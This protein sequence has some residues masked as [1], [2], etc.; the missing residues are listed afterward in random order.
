MELENFQAVLKPKYDGT[1][2]LA[3][4]FPPESLDFFILLSSLAGILGSLSQANYAAA[5]T[6]Q[7]MFANAQASRGVNKTVSIDLPL[8]QGTH[9]MSDERTAWLARQGGE[10]APIETV[11]S[12][13]DYAMSGRAAK[14]GC[15]QIVHGV[16]PHYLQERPLNRVPPLLRNVAASGHVTGQ[17]AEKGTERS[18]EDSIAQ[19]STVEAVTEVI[20]EAVRDKMSSLTTMDASEISLDTPVTNLGLDSLIAIEIKNWVTNTLQAPVRVG[21]IMDCSSLRALATL[22]AE[23]S[24]LIRA[25]TEPRVNGK[26]NGEPKATSAEDSQKQATQNSSSSNG[27]EV[28]LPKQP[29]PSLEATMEVFLESVANLGTQ[30]EL[31]RT[32]AAIN[33]FLGS[34]GLG[35]RLQQRLEKLANDPKVDNWL[36]D[37][38]GKGLW[39]KARDNKPRLN[40]FFGSHRLTRHPHSQAERAALISLA[41]YRYKLSLDEETVE[42]DYLNDQP[43]CMESVHWLFNTNRTPVEGC[44]RVDAWPGNEY[45]IAMRR[46]HVYKVPLRDEDGN[47]ILHNSLKSIF[48]LILEQA[49]KEANITS[50][51]TTGNRDTWAKVSMAPGISIQADSPLPPVEPAAINNLPTN[52]TGRFATKS[53]RPAGK[54]QSL[55]PP[56]RS[57]SLPSVW[58][59]ERL[60]L[61]VSGRPT[62]CSTTIPTAGSTR[63]S[64]SSYA[65]TGRPQPCTSTHELTA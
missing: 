52:M 41:A 16:S 19:A 37:I 51:L 15:N 47:I 54:M 11:L 23:R 38:Y 27:K 4:L 24:T 31:E 20:L 39:L 64:L 59:M 55:S 2:H 10:S 33:E 61:R 45:I 42:Q 5:S 57:L 17:L 21:E 53:S 29:L 60:R 28:E 34:E 63:R 62:S 7:D 25:V 49:P 43:L 30:A 46:G 6:Y 18:L 58:R 26:T 13:I 12:V 35:R 22:I 32:R 48:N 50:V 56:S 65:L 36:S 44:D 3:K 40:N 14:S 8:I 9:W 1:K